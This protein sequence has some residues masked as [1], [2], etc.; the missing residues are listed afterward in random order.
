MFVLAETLTMSTVEEHR[1]ELLEYLQEEEVRSNKE[2]TIDASNLRDIDTAG[3]QLL[4]SSFKTA[5]QKGLN[6]YLLNAGDYVLKMLE[7]SGAADILGNICLA[8]KY[9]QENGG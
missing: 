1:A 7:L 6:L 2:A 3:V 5:T 8:E 4:L 9:S